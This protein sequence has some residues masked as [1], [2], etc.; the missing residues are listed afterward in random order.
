MK[1]IHGVY[2]IF[3]KLED[4]IRGTLSRHPFIYTFVGG[5][6]IVLFWRGVW[7]TADYLE[8]LG[9]WYTIVFS[10]IGSMI[11]GVIILLAT[12]LFVSMFIGDSI[13]ISGIKKEKKV[14]EKEIEEVG[15]EIKKE[16]DEAEEELVQGQ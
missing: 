14:I 2:H 15:S 12:G 9:G 8:S 3:D 7:H 5:T 11:L 6:G 13:I 1:F 16:I 10:S 4:H